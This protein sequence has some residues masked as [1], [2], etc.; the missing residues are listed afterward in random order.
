MKNILVPTD[1]S[2]CAMHAM[3]MG[4]ALA[5]FFGATV[6]FFTCLENTNG[7]TSLECKLTEGSQAKK[8]YLKHVNVLLQK[9]RTEAAFR[10]VQVK[11]VCSPGKLIFSIQ[12]YVAANDIDFVVVGSHGS[13]GIDKFLLGSNT[14]KIVRTL[15][16]PV[17]VIKKPLKQY[18]FKSI[19]YASN[20]KK[21]EK[22]SFILFLE[23]IKKFQPEKIHLVG[24]STVGWSSLSTI[25]MEDSMNEFKAMCN[26]SA[27]QRHIYSDLFIESGIRHFSEKMDADLVV[28][29]NHNRH[30]EKRIFAGSTV[31]ALVQNSDLPVLSID[32]LESSHIHKA[33]FFMK[34]NK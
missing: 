30:P 28:I 25:E 2:D 6:H 12:N 20:F 10:N 4:L 23:F 22:E 14:Q 7:E 26:F 27:C 3:D 32:F 31:E 15:H 33:R 24:V 16:V 1:F 8:E 17:F 19:V 13:S 34:Q 9:W 18:E 21:E 5:E 29:S 11:T